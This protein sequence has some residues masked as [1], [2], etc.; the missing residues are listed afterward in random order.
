ML[1]RSGE[2][3]GEGLPS[4]RLEGDTTPDM[5]WRPAGDRLSGL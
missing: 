2:V 1:L 3:D 5:A 4:A